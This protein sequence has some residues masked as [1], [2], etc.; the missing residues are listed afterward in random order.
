MPLSPPFVNFAPDK[1]A[2]KNQISFDRN[3]DKTTA[4]FHLAASMSR[5]VTEKE[6]SQSEVEACLIDAIANFLAGQICNQPTTVLRVDHEVKSKTRAKFVVSEIRHSTQRYADGSRTKNGATLHL[7][8]QWRAS[9]NSGF[10]T[11]NCPCGEI[12]LHHLSDETAKQFEIGRQYFVDFTRD[13]ND[14]ADLDAPVGGIE[15]VQGT[16]V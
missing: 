5:W 4:H 9:E 10:Y 13:P 6:R 1:E 3:D 12:V 11:S 7:L 2:I 15:V 14:T 16:P 8:P